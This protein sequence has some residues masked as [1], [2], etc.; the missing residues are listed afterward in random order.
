[1]NRGGSTPAGAGAESCPMPLREDSRLCSHTPDVAAG[2]DSITDL[3]C[4]VFG[5]A[6]RRYRGHLPSTRLEFERVVIGLLAS[7]LGDL[8]NEPAEL[9]KAI[10]ALAQERVNQATARAVV[11][12]V[13]LIMDSSNAEL[14]T[15]CLAIAAGLSTLT[16]GMSQTEVAQMFNL[17]RQ[18]VNNRV[19]NLQQEL[20]IHPSRAMRSL[21]AQDAYRERAH[22]VHG[23]ERPES[24]PVR[25]NYLAAVGK[26]KRFCQGLVKAGLPED[27]RA[28]IR[29]ELAPLR[30]VLAA[31]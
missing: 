31:V 6:L 20:G 11:H 27:E 16:G 12:V 19:T 22:R 1:M 17:D 29:R 8:E 30:E 2:C 4:E 25:G 24:G 26:L 21:D 14:T 9:G 15:H 5:T 23:T 10:N 28:R 3:L 13:A 7:A 18:A